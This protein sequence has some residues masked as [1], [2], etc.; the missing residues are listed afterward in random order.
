D[1]MPDTRD[2][3]RLAF[4][5]QGHQTRVAGNGNEAVAAV[6]EE[7]FDVIV[8]DVEMPGMNGWE[9]VRQIRMLDGGSSIP[10]VMFTAYSSRED[11]QKAQEA[12]ANDVLQKPMLPQEL[13]AY[14]EKLRG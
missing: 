3:F 8:M 1:D 5:I 11:H 2:V 14:L 6:R 9:A 10:I 4:G 13:V 7:E 12:G